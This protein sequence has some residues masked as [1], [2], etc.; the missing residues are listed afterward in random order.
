MEI[1]PAT[2]ADLPEIVCLLADD[3]LGARRERFADPLPRAYAEAF[4]KIVRQDGNQILVAV[5]ADPVGGDRV[6]GCLQLIFIPGLT[7]LGMTRRRSG[8]TRATA[9]RASARPCSAPRSGW[10]ARPAAAWC[11]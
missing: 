3:P 4:A 8:S 9:A 6:V 1:R 5:E 10:R 11:N 7:R 2:A